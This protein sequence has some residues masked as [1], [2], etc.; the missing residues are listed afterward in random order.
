MAYPV[1]GYKS[2]ALLMTR[3]SWNAF[4]AGSGCGN[5]TRLPATGKQKHLHMGRLSWRISTTAGPGMKSRSLSTTELRHWRESP[6]AATGPVDRV[7]ARTPDPGSRE[8]TLFRPST[9][10][11]CPGECLHQSA[12]RCTSMVSQHDGSWR[13]LSDNRNK[14]HS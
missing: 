2:S 7:S 4:S 13:H 6:Q 10:K 12:R 3:M 8:N 14:T 11:G 9:Q 5:S 1:I